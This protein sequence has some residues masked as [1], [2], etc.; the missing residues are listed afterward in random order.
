M[1]PDTLCAVAASALVWLL[2]FPTIAINKVADKTD[3]AIFSICRAEQHADIA[4]G[5]PKITIESGMGDGGFRIATTSASSQRWFDYGIKLFHAFYHEDARQAF[6][7]A[8]AAD[9]TCA[10]C[11]WVNCTFHADQLAN[12]SEFC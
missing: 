6:D 3:F 2:A 11:L 9:P 12:V 1:K 4:G 7:N 8:V 10:M 5:T